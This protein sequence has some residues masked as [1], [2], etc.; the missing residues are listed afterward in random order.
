MIYRR[1]KRTMPANLQKAA[2]RTWHERVES[3]VPLVLYLRAFTSNIF[4]G[5]NDGVSYLPE[6]NIRHGLGSGVN[7]ITVQEHSSTYQYTLLVSRRQT[8]A[9]LLDNS[10]WLPAVQGLISWADLIFSECP[11]LTPGVRAELEFCVETEMHQ[12]TVLLAPLNSTFVAEGLYAGPPEADVDD[13]IAAAKTAARGVHNDE[14]VQKFNR[15]IYIPQFTGDDLLSSFVV[16]D[17]MDRITRISRLSVNDRKSI[18]EP[19]ARLQLFPIT[20]DGV[21]LGYRLQASEQRVVDAA[22]F[23]EDWWQYRFWSYFRACSIYNKAR[24]SG[25]MSLQEAAPRLIDLYLAM[26]NLSLR[27][28]TRGG[29]IVIKGDMEFAHRCVESAGALINASGDQSWIGAWQEL[30]SRVV[31][32]DSAIRTHPERYVFE[33]LIG[34]IFGRSAPA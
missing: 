29:Q 26:G 7:F 34:P 9:V 16:E 22:A 21:G 17:L 27:T 10:E 12:Q 23:N 14:L 18:I 2:A 4:V 25:Q 11:A 19:S 31:D 5:G 3:G 24:L 33:Q 8:P 28:T 20:Y 32:W 30:H 1:S 6:N 13:M 15:C